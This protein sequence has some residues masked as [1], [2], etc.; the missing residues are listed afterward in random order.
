MLSQQSQRV[1]SYY[2]IPWLHQ[3]SGDNK[4]QSHRVLHHELESSG[5]QG[6]LQLQ[7]ESFRQ[8]TLAAC[9][10]SVLSASFLF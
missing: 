4:T 7:V 2:K 6:G 10:S 1:P 8:E 9:S 5:K 3:H